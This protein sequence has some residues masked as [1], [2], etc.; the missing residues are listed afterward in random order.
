MKT[1]RCGCKRV[2]PLCFRRTNEKGPP[3]RSTASELRMTALLI[4]MEI[5]EGAGGRSTK[6]HGVSRLG[7][8][9]SAKQRGAELHSGWCYVDVDASTFSKKGH[10]NHCGRVCCVQFSAPP[11][12]CG[13]STPYAVGAISAKCAIP[14]NNSS[15][16]FSNRRRF[17]RTDRSSAITSTLSKKRS[18]TGRRVEINSSECL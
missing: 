1:R 5:E 12:L 14:E 15:S 11:C 17:C 4:S 10:R 9:M 13:E 3:L 16:F 18:T 8:A 2:Q 7:H 6:S